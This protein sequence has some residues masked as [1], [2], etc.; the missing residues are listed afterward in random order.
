[1]PDVHQSPRPQYQSQTVQRWRRWAGHWRSQFERQ[2]LSVQNS[3]STGYKLLLLPF[4]VSFQAGQW[5]RLALSEPHR[6]PGLGSTTEPAT[7]LPMSPSDVKNVPLTT[8]KLSLQN[9]SPSPVSKIY[10]WLQRRRSMQL[11]QAIRQHLPIVFSVGYRQLFDQQLF[12]Q[13]FS[14]WLPPLPS[15]QLP[16]Q[17]VSQTPRQLFTVQAQSLVRNLPTP[18]PAGE[19]STRHQHLDL[20]S[21]SLENQNQ[22]NLNS[23]LNLNVPTA[24]VAKTT[25]KR[26]GGR[27]MTCSP[28]NSQSLKQTWIDVPSLSVGYERHPFERLLLWLDRVLCWIETLLEN[29]WQAI[30]QRFK[31]ESPV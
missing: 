16:R 23:T 3:L 13:L 11:E 12:S 6:R 8:P 31:H 29:W 25:T 17:R 24:L 9:A 10:E 18:R 22:T 5:A 19:L 2:C 4:Y 28:S 20:V 27:A 21:P 1:M 26:S 15:L 30:R 14:Q 7:Q